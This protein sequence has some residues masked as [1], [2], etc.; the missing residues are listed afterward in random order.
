[1]GFH[2]W[3]QFYLQKKHKHVNCK[4]YRAR[5][6]KDTVAHCSQ[7]SKHG[8]AN[9]AL[10]GSPDRERRLAVHPGG[11]VSR[12]ELTEEHRGLPCGENNRRVPSQRKWL[13]PQRLAAGSWGRVNRKK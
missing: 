2:N 8:C 6:N 5:A 11:R 9:L 1:M 12:H 10:A 3:M 7:G 13:V 4:G